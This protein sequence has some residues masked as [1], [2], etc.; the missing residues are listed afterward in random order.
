MLTNKE[1]YE[2]MVDGK[3]ECFDILNVSQGAW[4]GLTMRH[5][6]TV[7]GNVYTHGVKPFV[8]DT[9]GLRN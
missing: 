3:V 4:I 7:M 1:E 6:K 2:E 9:L 8:G 5:N